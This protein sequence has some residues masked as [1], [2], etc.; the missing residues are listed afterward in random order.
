MTVFAQPVVAHFTVRAVGEVVDRMCLDD[1][2]VIAMDELAICM[3]CCGTRR[4]T[5]GSFGGYDISLL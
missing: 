5:S 2:S 4:A 3:P 1:G